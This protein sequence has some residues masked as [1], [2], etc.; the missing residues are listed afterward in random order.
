LVF[1]LLDLT[2]N[3]ILNLFVRRLNLVLDLGVFTTYQIISIFQLFF[4]YTKKVLA[5]LKQLF[6]NLDFF[7]TSKKYQEEVRGLYNIVR[8]VNLGLVPIVI[9]HI[10]LQLLVIHRPR[11]QYVKTALLKDMRLYP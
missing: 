3:S 4:T 7:L 6:K 1:F 11:F 9:I 5:L 10:A 8:A 2:P